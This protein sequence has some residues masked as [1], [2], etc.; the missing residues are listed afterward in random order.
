MSPG[1][2]TKILTHVPYFLW[3]G[4]YGF[5]LFFSENQF[6]GIWGVGRGYPLYQEIQYVVSV[7]LFKKK[8]EKHTRK[9]SERK[10]EITPGPLAAGS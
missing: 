9:R 4:R 3:H 1:L 7:I 10:R 2:Q 8:K 5:L 6:D